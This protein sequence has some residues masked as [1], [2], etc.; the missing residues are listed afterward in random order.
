[1]APGADGRLEDHR[2]THRFDGLQCGLF[3]EGDAYFGLGYLVFFESD[4]R[5]NLVTADGCNFR[6]VDAS[7]SRGFEQSQGVQRARVVDRPLENNIDGEAVV[8]QFEG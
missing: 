3:S 4:G 5:Q 2:M 6:R 7:D 8:A 1:A